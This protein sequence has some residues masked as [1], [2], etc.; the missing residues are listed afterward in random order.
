MKSNRGLRKIIV[1]FKKIKLF[2]IKIFSL[3]LDIK[4]LG[5]RVTLKQGYSTSFRKGPDWADEKSLGPEKVCT[6]I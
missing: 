5:G 1:L 6:P 3:N 2:F 4:F